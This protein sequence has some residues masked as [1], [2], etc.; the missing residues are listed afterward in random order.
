MTDDTWD[1]NWSELWKMRGQL[2]RGNPWLDATTQE[3]AFEAE[4]RQ[5]KKKLKKRVPKLLRR[6]YSFIS[7]NNINSNNPYTIMV[8]TS[9]PSM[10]S[11]T[12]AL[13]QTNGLEKP[14]KIDPRCKLMIR[15]VKKWPNLNL[16][17]TAKCAFHRNLVEIIATRDL[18]NTIHRIS[19]KK[20]PVSIELMQSVTDPT[21][22]Q[23]LINACCLAAI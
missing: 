20:Q 4:D 22:K 19:L 11:V 7:D 17:S 3:Q 1:N 10:G 2:W 8:S 21:L 13:V 9:G 12:L 6:A 18:M 15:L 23:E 16:G 5:T 14:P